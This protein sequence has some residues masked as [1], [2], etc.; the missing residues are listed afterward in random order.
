MTDDQAVLPREGKLRAWVNDLG[1]V[2]ERG[3]LGG[4]CVA[5]AH[6]I[7]VDPLIVRGA[8]VTTAVVGFPA[9]WIYVFAWATLP[10]DDGKGVFNRGRGGQLVG[11]G[12]MTVVAAIG[13]LPTL[14]AAYLLLGAI[15][16][17]GQAAPALPLVGWFGFLVIVVAA[18]IWAARRDRAHAGFSS[19]RNAA[20]L[21]RYARDGAT[22]SLDEV[23]PLPDG[24]GDMDAWRAQYAAWREQ[25]DAWRRA[26]TDQDPVAAE[27]E[28]R[29]Q[30][31][32]ELRAESMRLRAE[33]RATRP[34]TSFAYIGVTIG[35]ALLVGGATG[36]AVIP[37][38]GVET[39][40]TVAAFAAAAIVALAMVV[41]GALR[42]RSGFLALVTIGALLVGGSGIGRAALD[43]FVLPNAIRYPGDE[44]LT[45][46]Q[47]FGT[48][49]LDVGPWDG[50][51]GTTT[52][53]KGTGTTFILVDEDV[54][55]DIRVALGDGVVMA[56]RTD[57][58][59]ERSMR[60]LDPRPDGIVRWS[61]DAENERATRTIEIAQNSGEVYIQQIG[62]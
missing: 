58:N 29:R 51:E 36:A 62:Q 32:A 13:T 26:Q 27:R 49:N 3:W 18:L 14:I 41:A 5:V 57:E 61:I 28:L 10:D 40:V 12:L 8:F 6:R 37:A 7:G 19:G 52:V 56:D 50:G 46:D 48:L 23:P 15:F 11:L 2:R 38:H 4:V 9:I 17:F 21:G 16:T 30:Q 33:R 44:A 47:P 42:R 60:P 20:P 24:S 55:V 59:G 1:Y 35:I 54:D 53:T 22:S 39:A 45:I 34:R 43:G 25:H 31:Q